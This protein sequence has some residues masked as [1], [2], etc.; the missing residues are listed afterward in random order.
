MHRRAAAQKLRPSSCEYLRP[1]AGAATS[2][3]LLLKCMLG[4]PK[5]R[6]TLL[7][8]PLVL[9]HP[10]SSALSLTC[11]G[12]GAEYGKEACSSNCSISCF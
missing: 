8:L 11:P 9:Q 3:V 12:I 4:R 6:L 1:A 7:A 2:S 10:M 5:R